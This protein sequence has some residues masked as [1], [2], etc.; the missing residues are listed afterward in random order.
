MI[1]NTRLGREEARH[2][3]CMADLQSPTGSIA[4]RVRQIGFQ[5]ALAGGELGKCF[6]L[7]LESHECAKALGEHL[8]VGRFT[9]DRIGADIDNGGE[10][11]GAQ[12]AGQWV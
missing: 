2:A 8:L 10:P 11:F 3:G 6:G 7:R 4:H 12:Q 9:V 1:E 5:V